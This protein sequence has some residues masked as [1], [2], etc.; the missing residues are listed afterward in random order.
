[1]RD[2]LWC[3]PGHLLTHPPAVSSWPSAVSRCSRV[4]LSRDPK[5]IHSAENFGDCRSAVWNL[6]QVIV[7]RRFFT[8]LF[9]SLNSIGVCPVVQRPIKLARLGFSL[10]STF[11][12]ETENS[13]HVSTI[14]FLSFDTRSLILMPKSQHKCSTQL[15][16]Q[17][18]TLVKC[19]QD[20]EQHR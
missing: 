13:R 14:R 16:S 2:C 11:T 1:M 9:R 12:C 8:C 5:K 17:L 10:T 18:T 3:I 4:C 15:T 7:V 20:P 19:Q 6:R